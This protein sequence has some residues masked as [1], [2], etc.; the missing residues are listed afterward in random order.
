M[1]FGPCRVGP[2]KPHVIENDLAGNVRSSPPVA[3]SPRHRVVFLSSLRP[4]VRCVEVDLCYDLTLL[5]ST[6]KPRVRLRGVN[7]PIS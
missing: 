2:G 7:D 6:L 3:S 1:L 4:I 5:L